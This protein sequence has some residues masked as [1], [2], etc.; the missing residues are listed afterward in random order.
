MGKRRHRD[1]YR[2]DQFEGHKPDPLVRVI[3]ASKDGELIAVAVGASIRLL[4]C[5]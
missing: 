5:K 3:A 1:G 2:M 4:D